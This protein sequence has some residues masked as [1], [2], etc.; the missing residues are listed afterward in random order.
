MTDTMP[1]EAGLYGRVNLLDWALD[2]AQSGLLMIDANR[3]VIFANKWLLQRAGLNREHVVGRVLTEVIQVL[4]DSHF[5]RSLNQ[6]VS[7]GFPVLMSQSLHPAPFPIYALSSHRA[8]DMR[9]RQS[10]QIIPMAPA[11][12]TR[13]G[14][15]YMLIQIGDVTNTM[16]RERLLRAQ[17][18]KMSVFAHVDSLTGIGNRRFFDSSLAAELR[19]STRSRTSIGLVML[20]IDYFKAFNDHYGHPAGDRCITAVASVLRDVC[21]RPRDVVARYGGEEMVVILPDTDLPGSI[22]LAQEILQRLRSQKI[23][24]ADS[25]AG[26][27]VTLSA[28]VSVCLPGAQ[29][30]ATQ[31]LLQADQSQYAAKNKGRDRVCYYDPKSQ[32]VVPA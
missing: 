28:G 17:A 6:A 3:V 5:E 30:T 8:Q 16:L 23:P 10:I 25:P 2:S 18:D 15:R 12:S 19:A 11:E 32:A 22:R 24:H 31:L 4:K 7:T 1:P 27:F 21:R 13:A 29:T 26:P 20:D 9:L 14:Q